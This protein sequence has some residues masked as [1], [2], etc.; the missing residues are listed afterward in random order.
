MNFDDLNKP[1]P[2][3][4]CACCGAG[5]EC[6]VW[7][8]RLCYPCHGVWMGDDRFSSGVINKHLGT[9]DTVEQ[10]TKE[11]HAKYV[12]EATKRTRAWIAERKT[13]AA[14]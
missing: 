12:T 11:A 6:E 9:P 4:P 5:S 13:R 3:P 14:A 7:G 2:V 10:F 1:P 8:F